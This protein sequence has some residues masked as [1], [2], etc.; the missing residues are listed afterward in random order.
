[1]AVTQ[2]IPDVWAARFVSTLRAS[3]VYEMFVNRNY[4]G[5][6]TMAGD[7]VKVPLWSKSFTV[8]DYV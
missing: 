3:L 8:R 7:T 2:W 4:R 5:N 6:I 1:M